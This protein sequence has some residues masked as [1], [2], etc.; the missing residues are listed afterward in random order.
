VFAFLAR[1]DCRLII[2]RQQTG[3]LIIREILYREMKERLTA[4]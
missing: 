4:L 1:Y 2:C 3:G